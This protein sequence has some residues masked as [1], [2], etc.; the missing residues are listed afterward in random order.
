ME[1]VVPITRTI[2]RARPEGTT[3]VRLSSVAVLC[4]TGHRAHYTFVPQTGIIANTVTVFVA[5]ATFRKTIPVTI[6]DRVWR[7]SVDKLR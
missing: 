2:N 4:L 3:H 5:A 7:R 1:S 6:R